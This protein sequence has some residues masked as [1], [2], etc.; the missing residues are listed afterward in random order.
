MEA[1]PTMR[2]YRKRN[3][4]LTS[5][6]AKFVREY[7]IDGNATQAA[8]RAGYSKNTAHSQGPR[9]LE[10]VDVAKALAEGHQRHAKRCDI[11][12]DS[13]TA[14]LVADRTLARELEQPSPAITATMAIAKLHGMDV[15]K[16]EAAV[17]INTIER[18]IVDAS[19]PNTSD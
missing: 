12:I 7:A 14:E 15:N 17:S 11:S 3:A 4:M 8:I 19:Q 9:L 6:Q 13:L 10:N 16:V 18:V 2:K 5:K 1:L